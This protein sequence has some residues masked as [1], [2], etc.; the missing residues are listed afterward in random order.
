MPTFPRSCSRNLP[1]A[2]GGGRTGPD[3]G[4]CTAV[5]GAIRIL[6]ID[7]GSQATGYGV[8]DV[9]GSRA[10]AIRWGSIRTHGDHS[11]RLRRIY[12]DLGVIVR[13]LE[14]AEIAI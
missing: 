12:A 2:G 5:N 11:A 7:P 8:V 1:D 14:P 10:V 3:R 6:G 9:V 4:R 13:E